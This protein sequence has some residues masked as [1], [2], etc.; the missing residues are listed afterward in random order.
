M[1]SKAKG[2]ILRVAATLH[3]LFHIDNSLPVT[4]VISDKAITAAID[5][6][7]VCIQHAAYLAGRGNIEET[8]QAIIDGKQVHVHNSI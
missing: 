5:L 7:D 6:V 8:I 4:N 3:V 1:L 2:Q